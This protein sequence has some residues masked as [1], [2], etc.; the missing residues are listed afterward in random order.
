MKKNSINI[1]ME[2]KLLKI[3]KKI[4]LLINRSNTMCTF[5][6]SKPEFDLE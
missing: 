2:H 5:A 1:K 4:D 6:T 3:C